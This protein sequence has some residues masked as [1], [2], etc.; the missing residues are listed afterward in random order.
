MV[1]LIHRA[2]IW[3]RVMQAFVLAGAVW[4]AAP[5]A[6]SPAAPAMC[7][8]GGTVAATDRLNEPWWAKRHAGVLARIVRGPNPDVILIGDSI[9]HNYDKMIL[10]DEHFS[11]TWDRFYAPRHAINLGSGGDTTSNVLWRLRHGELDGVSPKVALLLVG[12][13]DTARNRTAAQTVCGIQ[14][15][16][17]E[18]ATRHPTTRVLLLGILPSEGPAQKVATDRAVNAMLAAL[19]AEDPRVTY[20]DVGTIFLRPD[21]SLDTS[22]FYDPRLPGPK[23]DAVHPDTFG[24]ARMAAAVEPTLARLLQEPPRVPLARLSEANSAIIPLPRLEQDS[25]DWYERHRAVLALN[26]TMRPRVVMIGDS[27]THFWAGQPDSARRNG[28]IAWQKLFGRMPVLNLGFGWDRTQNVLWRLRQGEMRGTAPRD[29]VINIGTNNLVGTENARANTPA[30][31]VA[32]IDAIVRAVREV[33]PASRITVMAIFPRGT[34]AT[35]P[36]RAPIVETNRLIAAHFAADRTVRYLDI[37]ARFLDRNGSLIPGMMIDGTHP[38]ERGYA[39]WAQAL[40]Q[41]GV[42]R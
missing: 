27:I 18:L 33:S 30:E 19:Y 1:R 17:G 20:L 42:G 4:Q 21:G 8:S 10:P 36:H 23:R 2:G 28:P 29:V 40:S 16:I 24:Q 34:A 14:A 31:V 37:G 38:G 39:V 35:D 13:N 7:E 12:T 25:Y 9:T 15:I 22:M 11:R 6:A 32:G 5:A 41:A 3:R 26:D